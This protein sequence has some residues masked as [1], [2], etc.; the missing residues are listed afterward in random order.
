[1]VNLGTAKLSGVIMV[2]GILAVAGTN[3][4]FAQKPCVDNAPYVYIGCIPL[5]TAQQYGAITVAG[6]IAFAIAW[7]IAGRQYHTIP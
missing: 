4:A 6:V 1:M 2:V 5:V 7:G 3:S